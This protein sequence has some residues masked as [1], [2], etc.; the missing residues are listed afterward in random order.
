MLTRLFLA[1]R[2]CDALGL[3]ID[4]ARVI[5]GRDRRADD[6]DRSRN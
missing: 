3:G 5:R 4:R 6:C 1:K 2:E